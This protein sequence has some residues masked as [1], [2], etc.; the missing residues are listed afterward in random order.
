MAKRLKV[1][2]PKSQITNGLIT[3]G[4][5]WMQEDGTE[6][7]GPYHTYT[8]GNVYTGSIFNNESVKLIPYKP[9][10]D[11]DKKYKEIV[12]IK[13]DKYIAPKYYI[14]QP[15]NEDFDKGWIDRYFVF[16]RNEPITS[17]I[18]VDKKQY[19]GISYS[20]KKKIDNWL[21]DKHS[22][23]WKITGTAEEIKKVNRDKIFIGKFKAPG[24]PTYLTN[25][26]EFSTYSSVWES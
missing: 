14:P 18:E 1:Y 10:S 5:Q 26:L 24:L 12:N 11:S 4:G 21:Y 15:T 9:Q 13:V 20:N 19:D 23:R 8:D 3:L 17:I 6:Y 16:K 2:Y 7:I 25:L 22:V